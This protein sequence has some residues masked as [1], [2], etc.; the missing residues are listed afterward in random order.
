[1]LKNV[2]FCKSYLIINRVKTKVVIL[3]F[4]TYSLQIGT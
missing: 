3:G 4:N 2:K 1:M